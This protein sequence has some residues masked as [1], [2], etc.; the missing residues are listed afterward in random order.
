M[1]VRLATLAFAVAS[2]FVGAPISVACRFQDPAPASAASRAAS[3]S[4]ADLRTVYDVQA[5]RLDLTLD[6]I[7]ERLSGQVTMEARATE[8]GVRAIELD[9]DA[10]LRV[11]SVLATEGAIDQDQPPSGA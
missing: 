3:Q 5:Y 7:K 4:A 8:D 10:K 9:L 6:T 1:H 11:L 2:T